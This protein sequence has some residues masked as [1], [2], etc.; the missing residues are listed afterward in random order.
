MPLH[1]RTRHR[2]TH[3]REFD[4]VYEAKVRKARGP[5]IVFTKPNARSEPRLG[6]A[7]STRVGHAVLRNT[8]KRLIRE[9]FRLEQRSV[10]RGEGGSYDLIV[11][12]RAGPE[13]RPWK[14]EM[15]RQ[16]LVELVQ[17]ADR[18]WQRRARREKA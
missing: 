14:L 9:A 7:V 3:A 12:V 1:F 10:P 18:E 5:L 2:L 4:A 8:W 16:V 17:D 15:M 13:V 11:S 6:L